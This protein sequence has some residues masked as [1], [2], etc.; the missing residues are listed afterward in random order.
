M[1]L[2]ICLKKIIHSRNP[3]RTMHKRTPECRH[4]SKIHYVKRIISYPAHQTSMQ[5]VHVLTFV[6]NPLCKAYNFLSCTSDLDARRTCVDNWLV[7]ITSEI[8]RKMERKQHIKYLS[9]YCH[10]ALTLLVIL[11]L[12]SDVGPKYHRKTFVF[13]YIFTS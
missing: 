3:C 10:T 8:Q 7:V 4:S 1:T 5:D 12:K 11:A 6:K 2:F 9:C 13:Q